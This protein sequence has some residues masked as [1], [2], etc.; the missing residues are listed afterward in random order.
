MSET[1]Q[2]EVPREAGYYAIKK[3]DTVILG[4]LKWKPAINAFVFVW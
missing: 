4:E 1:P 2:N 3:G